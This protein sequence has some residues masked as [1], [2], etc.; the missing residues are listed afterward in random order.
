MALASLALVGLADGAAAPMTASGRQPTYLQGVPLGNQTGLRLIVANDPPFVVDVDTGRVTPVPGVPSVVGGVQWVVAVAGRDAVIA[1]AATG[2]DARLFGVL[3]HGT[4]VAP[5][6][7]GTVAV[8]ASSGRG[9]WIR[10]A[11]DHARCRLRQVGLDGRPMT[12][13]RAFSCGWLDAAGT[14]GVAVSRARIVDPATDRTVFSTRAGIWAVAGE[15][16]LLVEPGVRF[17][18]VDTPRGTRRQIPWPKAY[19]G[20]G[21][22]A[23]D[24]RGAYVALSFGDPFTGPSIPAQVMDVWILSTATGEVTRLPGMP[25][26]VSLKFTS[27]Q[28][29]DDGRLVLLA[30]RKRGKGTVAVWRPGSKRLALKS[31][32]MPEPNTGSDSFAPIR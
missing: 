4:R 31:L 6:G 29:T 18:L 26:F 24:P 14:L 17:T 27:M 7:N 16:V 15:H 30:N 11:P 23:V 10:S 8:G 9:V 3:D 22:P 28:W 2:V 13:P 12:A 19:G 32:K 1:G 20:I 21:Q 25:A 5:L